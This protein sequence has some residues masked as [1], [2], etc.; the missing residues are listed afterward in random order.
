[1]TREVLR[2]YDQ[3]VIDRSD[4]VLVRT[5]YDDVD[6]WALVTALHAEQQAMYGFA[7][8]PRKLGPDDFDATG[9]VFLVGYL[10]GRAVGCGGLRVV[11]ATTAEVKRVYVLPSHRGQGYGRQILAALETKAEQVGAS[12]L[13]LETGARNTQAL[14]L[15]AAAG[16]EGIAPY[17]RHRDPAVNRAFAKSIEVASKQQEETP[18]AV[19]GRQLAGSLP[20][21]PQRRPGPPGRGITDTRRGT[22]VVH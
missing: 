22:A 4:L 8:D 9:G 16:Y 19:Q 14:R 18:T 7:D 6:A 13:I 10:D 2:A 3:P 5:R 20:L 11:D 21:G 1:M 17:V 15:Y 12:A